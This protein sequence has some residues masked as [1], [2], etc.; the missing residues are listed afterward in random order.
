[1]GLKPAIFKQLHYY[2]VKRPEYDMPLPIYQQ[3][4]FLTIA[5]QRTPAEVFQ[6]VPG[7]PNVPHAKWNASAGVLWTT[8]TD[9]ITSP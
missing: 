1:M 7:V 2:P 6:I 3:L 5:V 4:N 8:K 9:T